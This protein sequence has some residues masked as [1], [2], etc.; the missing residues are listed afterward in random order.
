MQ[1]LN[2]SHND[3]TSLVDANTL[4]RYL[5]SIKYLDQKNNPWNCDCSIINYV[6]EKGNNNVLNEISDEIRSISCYEER[7]SLGEFKD[8]YCINSTHSHLYKNIL[9]LISMF[10]FILAI[11]FILYVLF[12]L[13][14]QVFLYSHN[15]CLCWIKNN[16]LNKNKKYDVFISFSYKDENFIMNDFLPRLEEGAM[17]YKVCIDNRDWEPGE[18]IQDNIIKS[19]LESK[20]TVILL[21]ENYVVSNW[22]MLE[23]KTAYNL[24]IK[25]KSTKIII[26]L[27]GVIKNVDKLPP[28]LRAYLQ[29][30]TY[31]KWGE[32]NFWNKLFF[33]LSHSCEREV[34]LESEKMLCNI[35]ESTV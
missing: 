21:S 11:A 7:L 35:V 8:G 24:M 29:M 28:E 25:E 33:A 31:L 26:I 10:G 14:I 13:Q 9:L 34:N 3:I 17:P 5:E 23:F 15:L 27:Y 4:T 20:F 16:D 12:K 32:P 19:I 6:F 1:H 30:C 22:G 2:V 18:W